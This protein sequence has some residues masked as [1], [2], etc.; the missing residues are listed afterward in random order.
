MRTCSGH[1]HTAAFETWSWTASQPLAYETVR[2]TLGSL[3][4]GV[5]RAKGF[6][7]LAEAPDKR[8]VAHVVGR[9]VDI[10]PLGTWN[11]ARPRTELVFISLDPNVDR[12]LVHERL[13]ETVAR[14]VA[15]STI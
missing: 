1:G 6:L 3:P 13:D 2:A 7:Y 12:A 9:R 11:G 4:V 10:R 14:E 15:R 5:F 8:V